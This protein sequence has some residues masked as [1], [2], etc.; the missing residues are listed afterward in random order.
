MPPRLPCLPFAEVGLEATARL[1][2]VGRLAR[3]RRVALLATGLV[4]FVVVV[5]HVG[6]GFVRVPRLAVVVLAAVLAAVVLSARR[7]AGLR[8]LQECTLA[9]TA[10]MVGSKARLSEKGQ[11]EGGRGERRGRG[12]G[13]GLRWE[14]SGAFKAHPLRARSGKHVIRRRCASLAH[15]PRTPR[16]LHVPRSTWPQLTT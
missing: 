11:R 1:G 5:R 12:E 14:G 9:A 8:W 10:G 13:T 16:P 15:T 6:A 3:P 2:L 7:D 4:I